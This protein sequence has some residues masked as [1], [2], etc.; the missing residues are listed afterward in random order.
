[1]VLMLAFSLYCCKERRGLISPLNCD[2]SGKFLLKKTSNFIQCGNFAWDD[3]FFYF[4]LQA[5]RFYKI[6][7]QREA[8]SKAVTYELWQKYV[9]L[10]RLY[11][12]CKFI[13]L[14]EILKTKRNKFYPKVSRIFKWEFLLEVKNIMFTLRA[15][16]R[17]IQG[18]V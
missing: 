10:K 15:K 8:A 11:K 18:K 17:S 2:K 6:C 12:L 3:A 5:C 16:S 13:I 9:V 14:W 7:M 1:M 4:E